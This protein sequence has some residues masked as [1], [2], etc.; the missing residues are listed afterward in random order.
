MNKKVTIVCCYNDIGQYERLCTSLKRQNIEYELIGID[1]CR[2]KFASCSSALNAVVDA[3]KTEYVVYSH[4]DIELPEADMLERFVD[5]LEQTG[6]ADILGV[7]GAIDAASAGAESGM[8]DIR[9]KPKTIPKDGTC[10][11]SYVRHGRGLVCAGEVEF[12]G[13]IVCDTVDECFFGGRTEVFRKEPFDE[14]LCD[15]WHLY[16]VERCLR[17]RVQ[18][19]KVWVCDL[20]L[21]HHSSGNINHAYNE[22][23]R[24]IAKHY[25]KYPAEEG[26]RN[27]DVKT[28]YIRTVCGSARTDWLHRNLFYWKREILFR[29][30]RL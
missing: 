24:R 30:H 27:A 26:G 4:Q 23:F 22:N 5:Y 14:K 29:L 20:S 6:K 17:A 21:I 19:N 1:N 13:M 8:T 18:G 3:I 15:N 11:A 9:L 10:V 25:A 7:A 28:A 16:A 12:Q 2:Q